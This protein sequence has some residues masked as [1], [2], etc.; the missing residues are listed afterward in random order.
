MLDHIR[1]LLI[2]LDGVLYVEDEP[3]PGAAEAVGRLRAG[4]ALRFVTN[5]TARSRSH[6]LDKL[7]RLGFDVAEDELVTP[8]ALAVSPRDRSPAQHRC[9]GPGRNPRRCGE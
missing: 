8:A 4:L 6:T 7:T 3:I 9:A 1:A 2:D 5:T